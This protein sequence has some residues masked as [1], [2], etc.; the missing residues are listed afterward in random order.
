M[1]KNSAVTAM[2]FMPEKVTSC[3]SKRRDAVNKTRFKFET[4]VVA[5][6]MGSNQ[7]SCL[8]QPD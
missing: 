4:Q 6:G 1:P 3:L 2:R 5:R 8:V 7:D